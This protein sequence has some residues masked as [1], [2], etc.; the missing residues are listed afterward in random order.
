MIYKKGMKYRDEVK[1]IKE[2][3]G[4]EI[5]ESMRYLGI[6]ICGGED[7]FKKQ[8]VEMKKAENLSRMTYS[9]I[10]KSSIV[11]PGNTGPLF[12]EPHVQTI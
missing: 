10:E 3:G 7:I 6:E 4:I 1:N 2:I 5:V 9:I 12:M 8:K 11:A